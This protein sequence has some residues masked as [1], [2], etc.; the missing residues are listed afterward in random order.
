MKKILHLHFFRVILFPEI[1]IQN[2]S[3]AIALVATSL[4]VQMVELEI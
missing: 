1:L 4:L 3:V 2:S